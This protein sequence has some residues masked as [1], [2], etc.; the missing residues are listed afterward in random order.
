VDWVVNAHVPLP[1]ADASTSPLIAALYGSGRI[2]RHRPASPYVPGVDIDADQ[3]P[4]DASGRVDRRLYVLGVLCEGA[5]FYNNLVPS[6]G[7]FSRP[8]F[9]ADRAAR[10]M[11]Q[12]R[13]P[14]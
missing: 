9:D 13:S 1:A 6:P 10:T 5:V 7:G 4:I 14:C 3:H 2:R 11:L 12:G 8:I